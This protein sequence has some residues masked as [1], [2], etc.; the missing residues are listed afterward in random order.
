MYITKENLFKS[1][2]ITGILG[3]KTNYRNLFIESS[4]INVGFFNSR[5]GEMNA[6][7]YLVSVTGTGATLLIATF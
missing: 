5:T 6:G 1:L 4:S 2:K 3:W 7:A